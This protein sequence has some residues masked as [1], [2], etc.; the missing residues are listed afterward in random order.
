MDLMM[1][2]TGTMMKQMKEWRTSEDFALNATSGTIS[3]YGKQGHLH[4]PTLIMVII[5]M[6]WINM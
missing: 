3:A 1:M 6:S 4:L 5:Q 2:A